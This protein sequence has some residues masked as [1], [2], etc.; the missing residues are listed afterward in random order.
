[1]HIIDPAP[2][3]SPLPISALRFSILIGSGT[4]SVSLYSHLADLTIWHIHYLAI[5]QPHK[6]WRGAASQWKVSPLL[7]PRWVWKYFEIFSNKRTGKQF[8]Q[9]MGALLCSCVRERIV[10]CKLTCTP[11]GSHRTHADLTKSLSHLLDAPGTND[12]LDLFIYL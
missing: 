4:C 9:L 2:L 10:V 6:H 12:L 1:M 8:S 5:Y 11:P 7:Q 3:S